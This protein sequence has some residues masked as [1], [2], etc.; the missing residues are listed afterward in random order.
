MGS[1]N[2]LPAVILLFLAE[3]LVNKFLINF[4]ENMS[5]FIIEILAGNLEL[6][7]S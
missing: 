4:N 6:R 7:S 5:F 1:F 3:K 2:G